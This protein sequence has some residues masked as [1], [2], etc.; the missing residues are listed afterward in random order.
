[1]ARA[2]EALRMTAKPPEYSFTHLDSERAPGLLPRIYLAPPRLRPYL[3]AYFVT[4]ATPLQVKPELARRMPEGASYIGFLRGRKT[5]SGVRDEAAL[6]AG[7]AQEGIHIIPTWDY[8]FQ[9]GL[10]IHPGAAA[11][12]LGRAVPALTNAII[13]LREVW[14]ER[15]DR[16]LERLLAA[17]TDADHIRLLSEA[18]TE[19]LCTR[20][21]ASSLSVRLAGAVRTASGDARVSQLARGLGTTVRTL[22]RKF[23][24]E[25]GLTPKGYQRISRL[26]KVFELLEHIPEDWARVATECGY[27]DQSHLI[28]D[29]H[30]V[31]G[32]PPERF[33]RNLTNIAGLRVGFILERERGG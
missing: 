29:C 3:E 18:V 5:P 28:D 13:P 11:L 4:E 15:A 10:R 26:A 8:H 32:C 31:L 14:G 12:V 17:R 6:V 7:G 16:L 1:M 23:K 21:S 30:E 22:E 9:V 25:V 33:L 20:T 2:V 19:V 27:Y 24:A